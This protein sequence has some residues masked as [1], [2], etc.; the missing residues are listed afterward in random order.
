MKITLKSTSDVVLCDGPDDVGTAGKFIGPLGEGVTET[1]W[2][3]RI[4]RPLRGASQIPLDG[5]LAV[6]PVSFTVYAEFAD[7][8]A[9]T[10][11]RMT[12]G[13][14]LPRGDA[15]LE[16]LHSA[17]VLQ[18]FSNAVLQKIRSVQNG[19]A[20]M[21]EYLFQCGASAVTD[22]DPEA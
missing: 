4:K 11:H 12:W 8:A 6:R 5:K 13:E 10:S 7:E 18:T 14:L 15:T 9:A 20:V 3:V 19:T 17:H 22:P 21:N 16:V 1:E 2:T